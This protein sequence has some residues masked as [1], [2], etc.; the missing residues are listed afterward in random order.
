MSVA[1]RHS[2]AQALLVNI[3]E[4][5]LFFNLESCRVR[6]AA[7][8]LPRNARMLVVQMLKGKLERCTMSLLQSAG[9]TFYVLVKLTRLF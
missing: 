7:A 8:H 6:V 4:D 9:L 2:L 5:L 3:K 1:S